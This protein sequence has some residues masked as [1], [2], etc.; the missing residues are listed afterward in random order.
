MKHDFA[1][2]KY[3]VS[4]VDGKL[5][6]L[7]YGEP[8]ERGLTG[9]NLVYWMLVEVDEFKSQRDELL[10]V[11]KLALP[12]LQKLK[13]EADCSYGSNFSRAQAETNRRNYEAACAAIAKA[14]GEQHGTR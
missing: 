9:D 5:T 2:G 14:E 13:F 11:L 6:A 8:W 10:A 12:T 4:C 3:S 1:N 7:R